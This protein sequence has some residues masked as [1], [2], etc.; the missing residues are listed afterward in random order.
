M[1]KV[2][3][4]TLQSSFSCSSTSSTHPLVRFPNAVL[5]LLALALTFETSNNS[6]TALALSRRFLIK[7]SL[8]LAGVI[9]AFSINVLISPKT[10][11]FVLLSS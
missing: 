6:K 4:R 11:S 5:L 10:T 9:W 2:N 8:T 7:T 3:I 1:V